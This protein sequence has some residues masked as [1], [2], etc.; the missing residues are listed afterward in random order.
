MEKTADIYRI[1]KEVR[2]GEK[3]SKKGIE[4][5]N[6]SKWKSKKVL[7][8]KQERKQGMKEKMV[9]FNGDRN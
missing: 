1:A 8:K 3:E 6:I 5:R 2:L 7:D 9:C 4:E